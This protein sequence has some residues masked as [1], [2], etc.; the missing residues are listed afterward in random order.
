M[1]H[2]H[3]NNDDFEAGKFQKETCTDTVRRQEGTRHKNCIEWRQKNSCLMSPL[4][5]GWQNILTLDSRHL[6]F[7][8]MTLFLACVAFQ[9]TACISLDWTHS[10]S[11]FSRKCFLILKLCT[12]DGTYKPVTV[13]VT[14]NFLSLVAKLAYACAETQLLQ[15]LCIHMDY[16]IMMLSFLL[17]CISLHCRAK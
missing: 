10:I 3:T 11:G 2:K 16:N 13:T 4:S 1:N 17:S 15:S 14:S 5:H 7:M 12:R 9:V 8:K 6:L